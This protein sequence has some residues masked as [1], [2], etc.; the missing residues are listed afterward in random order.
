MSRSFRCA[1]IALASIDAAAR[2]AAACSGPGAA[3]MIARNEHLGWQL[4]LIA[5]AIAA[6]AAALIALR[7]RRWTKAW[8]MLVLIALHPGWYYSARMGDCGQG[9]VSGSSVMTCVIAITG[10]LLV[11]FAR[12]PPREAQT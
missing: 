3:G 5:A 10:M 8:P 9:L 12:K 2:E 6:V 11:I 1:A 4:W 7:T